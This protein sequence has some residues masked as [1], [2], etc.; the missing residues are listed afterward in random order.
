MIHPCHQKIASTISHENH[1][2]FHG[3]HRGTRLELSRR[4]K[5]DHLR[6]KVW[7]QVEAAGVVYAE[8]VF[9]E[10][11]SLTMASMGLGKENGF[12]IV[13]SQTYD[14]TVRSVLYWG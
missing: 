11:A 13:L 5:L 6:F 8:A 10:R 4:Y 2:C 14:S 3:T 9:W 1:R 7:E 12:F